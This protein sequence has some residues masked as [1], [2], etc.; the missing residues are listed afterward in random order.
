M[1]QIVFQECVKDAARR[2]ASPSMLEVDPLS[3]PV[4]LFN[5]VLLHLDMGPGHPN[6]VCR[7]VQTRAAYTDL[8]P[9]PVL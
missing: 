6:P 1:Y 3:D 8:G 2:P 4:V 5:Q 7:L 9:T